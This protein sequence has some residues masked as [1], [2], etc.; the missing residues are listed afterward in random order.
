MHRETYRDY[1]PA[2]IDALYRAKEELEANRRYVAENGKETLAK[3]FT[4]IRYTE[5]NNVHFSEVYRNMLKRQG[6]L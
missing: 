1:T 3:V 6:F 2:A 4:D 5:K